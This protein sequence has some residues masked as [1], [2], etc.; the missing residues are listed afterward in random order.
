MKSARLVC[1]ATWLCVLSPS[2]A[3]AEERA[4]AFTHVRLVDGSGGVPLDDAVVVVS[5]DRIVAA[6]PRGTA[7]PQS[8]EIRDERGRTIIPGL[9]SDHSHVGQVGGT[10]IGA[11]NYTR[12]KIEAELRQYRRFGVTTIMALGN[13]APLFE[14][15][16]TEAHAGQT[17]GADLFGVVRGIGVP[18]GAPPQ[19]MLK[20]GPDQIFRPRNADEAKAAV[21]AMAE[22][23]T[24]LI[25]IW[26]DDFGG[27]LPVKMSPEVYAAVIDQAH[28]RG[29]RVAAH[30]H[31]L[32]DAKAIVAAGADILAHGV[33][34]LPVD[35][36]F[37]QA[38][39][40]KGVWYV[41]TLALDEATFAWAD[42]AP[43]TQMPVVRAALSPELARQ[44]GSPEW[45]SKVL[46]DPK[47]AD[48]RASL[49]MN[50]R[51]LKILYD[52]GVKIG[53]GTDS[54][55]TPL[56]VA[57]VAEHRELALMVEAGLAPLQALTIATANAAE[58]LKLT[59]RGRIAAG[60]RADFIVLD[61]DPSQ[62]IANSQSIREVWL[63]GRVFAR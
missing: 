46:A 24:D 51:N 55:A 6:G 4:V 35:L 47:T 49:A 44:V 9:V 18:E 10:S 33:R 3:A 7:I 32:A 41:P 45:R 38:M 5:G 42:Q 31:D 20:L 17:D 23:K 14:S 2:F 22:R 60:L 43:W 39:K 21:D 57:G 19:A 52:S 26:L 58:V 37:I 34:D 8:A 25:K 11:A 12:L 28:R 13:N 62:A 48:A 53:F 36:D 54:G 61:A 56:R 30:I 29:V 27:G 59:D 1:V 40:A 15:I 63:H 16:R 50:L